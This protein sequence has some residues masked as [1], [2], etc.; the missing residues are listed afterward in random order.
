MTTFFL[1]NFGCRA[2]QADGA[3]LKGQLLRAG[4][5]EAERPERSEIVVLNTCT[6]T[7]AADSELRQVIRRIHRQSPRCRILVTGCY[8]QRSPEEIA[9]LPGVAWV[10]GNSHK[11]HIADL[12]GRCRES[13]L[14]SRGSPAVGDQGLVQIQK[15]PAKS[16]PVVSDLRTA[17]RATSQ[18]GPQTEDACRVLVGEISDQF[19]FAPVYPDDRTRPT[20]KIQDGCN[21]RCSFCVIP[22]VRGDSR[23][24]ASEVVIG[25][26]RQLE[27]RGYHEVVLSGINLGSYGRDLDPPLSFFSLLERILGETSVARIRISSI[28]PMD[29]SPKLIRLMAEEARLARHFH[30]PLQSGCDRLLRQMN[31]RYWT[32]QYAERVLAIRREIPDCG[33][34]AD[35]MVGFPGETDRDHASSLRFI[36]SMPFTYVHVF[37]YS[38][39]PGTPAALQPGQ[40]N[41]QVVH[42]RGQEI[43]QVI[44]AKRSA[45]LAGQVGRKISALT[46]TEI[47]DGSLVALSTNYLRILLPASPVPSNTLLYVYVDRTRDGLL[48]GYGET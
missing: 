40:V 35:V 16:P 48:Y 22:F 39:R 21:A 14:R 46:L 42:R 2:S 23:S 36:D 9:K 15:R 47:E 43:R 33:I 3:A 31:R 1:R 10:V 8:A 5:T 25:Q 41:A 17:R 20:V 18:S 32:T 27:E 13:E 26:I 7:A 11:H 44:A 19:H 4:L 12:L 30:V 38:A 45:F 6:V 24:L 29:V 34:G 37:P 28:E